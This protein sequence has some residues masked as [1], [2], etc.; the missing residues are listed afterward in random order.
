MK[1]TNEIM[2]EK[3]L[4]KYVEDIHGSHYALGCE[5]CPLNI[6]SCG[7]VCD[8]VLA[9]RLAKYENIGRDFM[10]LPADEVVP[11]EVL[12][13]S[14]KIVSVLTIVSEKNKIAKVVFDSVLGTIDKLYGKKAGE[15]DD[16]V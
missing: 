5:K 11:V 3:R 1:K 14:L 16:N 4:T 6:N 2:N 15:K 13:T 12:E 7:Y 9:D 10:K 8:D